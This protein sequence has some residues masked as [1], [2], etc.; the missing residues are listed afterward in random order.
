MSP[1][2]KKQPLVAGKHEEGTAG[3]EGGASLARVH[4]DA[5]AAIKRELG[6]IIVFGALFAIAVM[7]W[8]DGLEEA[9]L[10]AGYGVGAALWIRV[11]AG[12]L[13]LSLRRHRG[14]K[15]HGTQQ[16]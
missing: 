13:L 7:H 1:R 2:T 3:D 8:F 15:D 16:E 12:G 14:G 11:R 6:A 10:L 5:L 9:V 4:E